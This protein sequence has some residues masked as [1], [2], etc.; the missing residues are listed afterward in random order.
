MLL[1]CLE[2]SE[3]RLEKKP[4]AIVDVAHT[5]ERMRHKV[6]VGV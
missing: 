4:C 5:R 1:L 2:I 6:M 3:Q